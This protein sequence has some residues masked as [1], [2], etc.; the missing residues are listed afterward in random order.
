MKKLLVFLLLLTMI[1]L[2]AGCS[3]QN[4]DAPARITTAKVRYFDGSCDTLEVERW[5]SSK[6]GTVTVYTT[7]GRKVVI[8]ANNIILIEE[9]IDQYEG[10]DFD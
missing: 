8:G 4:K 3:G 2:L 6:S 7:E 9:T 1:F 10:R 5:F